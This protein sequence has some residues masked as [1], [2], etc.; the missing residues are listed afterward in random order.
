VTTAN[1]KTVLTTGDVAKICHVAPRTVSKWFDSGKLRGYRIPGSRD[2][3]IPLPQLVAFMRAHGMP[4][5]GLD[6]GVCRVLVIDADAGEALA[7]TLNASPR[8]RVQAAS[9]EFEAGV[10]AQQLNPHVIVLAAD[11][12]DDDA[13]AVCRNIKSNAAFGAATVIAASEG[14]GDRR[15][16]RLRSVFDGCIDKPY[17]AAQ[18]AQV[19]EEVTN[20]IT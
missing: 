17:S 11:A 13:L 16:E 14:L 6:G 2:R 10:L 19:I 9:N 12:G 15:R 1:G 20:L 3:R 4:L 8:Y 18:A 7:E 5:D